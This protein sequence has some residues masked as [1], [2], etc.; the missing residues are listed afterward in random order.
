MVQ[1]AKH[2]IRYIPL[3]GQPCIDTAE[4]TVCLPCRMSDADILEYLWASRWPG[5][6]TTYK[7]PRRLVGCE[8]CQARIKAL[9]AS[10]GML[11]ATKHRLRNVRKA[12]GL[13]P[14]EMAEVV[15]ID[16]DHYRKCES[17]WRTPS[18]QMASRINR[19]IVEHNQRHPDQ[20]IKHLLSRR[21]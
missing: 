6:P 8:K 7:H 11:H 17:G 5:T 2:R 9:D 21:S 3:E 12:L 14:I 19:A 16:A 13:S 4:L 1:Q 10:S 20:L 18:V 15:G